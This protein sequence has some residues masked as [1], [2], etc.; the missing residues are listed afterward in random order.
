MIG[1]LAVITAFVGLLKIGPFNEDVLYRVLPSWVA[2]VFM[3]SYLLSGILILVGLAFA[4]A[5]M[6]SAGLVTVSTSQ[7]ARTISTA[8]LLGYKNAVV[9]LAFA[10]LVTWACW[11]RLAALIRAGK[12]DGR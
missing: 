4:R 9:P 3:S 12:P 8:T 7:I 6:E 1:G 5:D 10:I 11:V 2:T